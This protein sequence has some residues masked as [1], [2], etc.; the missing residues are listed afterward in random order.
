MSVAKV[1]EIIC[2]GDTIENALKNGIKDVTKTVKNVKQ[3]NVKHVEAIV[4]KN[5]IA[6]FRV[7][8]NVTFVV[9]N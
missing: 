6:S 7:N 2:E 4:N 9:E 8:A 5:K 1:I 3:I